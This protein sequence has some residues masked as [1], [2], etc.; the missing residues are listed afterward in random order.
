[1]DANNVDTSSGWDTRSVGMTLATVFFKWFASIDLNTFFNQ[2][3]AV[4]AVV[5]GAMTVVINY[6][7][8]KESARKILSKKSKNQNPKT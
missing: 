8:F 5:C 6:E 4:L 2:T 7:K 3:S 1:M